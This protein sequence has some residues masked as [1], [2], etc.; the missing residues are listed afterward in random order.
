MPV[1]AGCRAGRHARGRAAA[2]VLASATVPCTVAVPVAIAGRAIVPAGGVM[3]ISASKLARR[4]TPCPTSHSPVLSVIPVAYVPDVEEDASG[5][6]R[7][8]RPPRRACWN[9]ARQRPPSPVGVVAA[10]RLTNQITAPETLSGDRLP[11]R[12][13]RPG[14]GVAAVGD[15]VVDRSTSRWR[16]PAG[17]RRT[18]PAAALTLQIVPPAQGPLPTV[19]PEATEKRRG[20]P[21]DRRSQRPWRRSRRPREAC[22]LHVRLRGEALRRARPARR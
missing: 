13:W 10:R 11:E 1:S 21:V 12:W 14:A 20:A 2:R 6:P 9:G 5:S 8:R 18:V 7:R 16:R 19:P 17:R 4:S 15:R 22:D 3:P